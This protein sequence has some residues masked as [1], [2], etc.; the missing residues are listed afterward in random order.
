MPGPRTSV[1]TVWIP[2][3]LLVASAWARLAIAAPGDTPPPAPVVPIPAAPPAAP[4]ATAAPA[5]AAKLAEARLHFQQGVALYQD[6]NYDAALAEFQGAYAASSEPIVLYNMGLTLKALF[7]YADAIDSLDRYLKVGG[8]RT[9]AI[10]P[11]RRAEVEGIITEMKSLLADV[12][13]VVQPP[14]ANIRVDGRAVT[15]GIEGI[16]KLAAGTHS[17]EAS[18]AEYTTDHR[19]ITVVAGVPQ[20]V[21]LKLNPIPHTGH[22]KIATAQPGAHVSVDG[23]DLG[24][25]PVEVELG[26]GGHHLDVAA[27]GFLTNSSELAVAPGQSREMTISLDL[28]PPPPVTPF[29]QRWWFWGGAAVVL[30]VAGTIIFWPHTQGPLA[31]TTGTTNAD[32]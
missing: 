10:T 6:H 12:T 31:G 29:Y 14:Q 15:M 4:P 22:V 28:P 18:Q 9:D 8:A 27:Q 3:A 11:E 17:I 1:S 21:S 20:S 24:A 25:A 19:D 13:V 30:A 5:S 2:T 23:R 16:V 26:A 32:P 7:R